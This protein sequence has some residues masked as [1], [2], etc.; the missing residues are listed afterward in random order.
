MNDIEWG[1]LR[2]GVISDGVRLSWVL[3]RRREM[4]REHSDDTNGL[5]G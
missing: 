5:D 4:R 1:G 2:T 3:R